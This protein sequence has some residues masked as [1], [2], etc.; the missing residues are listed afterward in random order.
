MRDEMKKVPRLRFRGFSEDWEQRK[1]GEVTEKIG[2]GKTPKGGNSNY[3]SHGVALI[4]S[5]NIFDDRVN[6]N[7]IAYISDKVD[8][9]MKNSRVFK[10]DVLLN[11]T[12]AS[13]G[14]SAVYQSSDTAN[15]NQHVCIIRPKDNIVSNFI[16]LNISSTKGQKEIELNQAGGGREGLNFQQI[17]KMIFSY[18]SYDEQQV[19]GLFFEKINDTITLHQR[20]L[21]QLKELKKA[22]LQL[23]F[24]KKDETVPR[25]RFADFE[26]DWQLCKLGETFSIIMGQSPNSEN[27]TE[28]PDDYILVQGNSDMKNN[29]VVPRIWTTQVTKKAEKGDLILSVRAPVGEIGKTDYNVVLGRGVAAVKGND[30]IFQQLRKMKDSGYWTRYSTGSTFESINSNDI[31]EALINIPNKDEQQKI[32]DLFTHLDDAIILNQNKLNQLKSLK[33]SYLQNMFI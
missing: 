24:P 30:F 25:V 33:K 10:N 22:Y 8:N 20:K 2:S 12:G 27:Y 28:N 17:A 26:D 1:L 14:R 32:G 5:Q 3:Q 29:K 9:D 23:M 16:Q 11:I 15:V 4:R 19:I 31:K 18:P 6:N 13:I 21:D 7:D